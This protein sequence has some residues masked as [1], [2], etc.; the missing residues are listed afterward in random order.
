MLETVTFSYSFY[1]YSRLKQIAIY[2]TATL[3][4]VWDVCLA[5]VN[6]LYYLVYLFVCLLSSIGTWSNH[7]QHFHH[8]ISGNAI[9]PRI[10]CIIYVWL[11]HIIHCT[12]FQLGV[13]TITCI[14]TLNAIH[15]ES[16]FTRLLH[17]RAAFYTDWWPDST[18]HR[19]CQSSL[20]NWNTCKTNHNKPQVS[21]FANGTSQKLCGTLQISSGLTQKDHIYTF[22]CHSK[23]DA[24]RMHKASVHISFADIIVDTNNGKYTNKDR[25]KNTKTITHHLI[26]CPK[27]LKLQN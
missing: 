21:V 7:F 27:P 9:V 26:A 15:I 3:V 12:S 4:V 2:H 1:I 5:P 11:R 20:L 17:R 14:I 10:S 16:C 23:G 18:Q 25:H 13:M 6:I 24:V 22:L 19:W 8:Y